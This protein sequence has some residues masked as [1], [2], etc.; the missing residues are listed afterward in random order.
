VGRVSGPRCA[1]CNEAAEW[2]RRL[3]D[4]VGTGGQDASAVQGTRMLRQIDGALTLE[5]IAAP[6]DDS[7]RELGARERVR[8]RRLGFRAVREARSSGLPPAR[9]AAPGSTLPRRDPCPQGGDGRQANNRW[10]TG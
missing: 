8:A 1:I 7:V 4:T 3:L 2:L 5:A 10:R 6:L 9:W